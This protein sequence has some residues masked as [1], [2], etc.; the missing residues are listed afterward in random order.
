MRPAKHG[1]SHI[2]ALIVRTGFRGPEGYI[3]LKVNIIIWEVV[4]TVS[5]QGLNHS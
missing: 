1:R 4:A 2:G 3:I 5:M